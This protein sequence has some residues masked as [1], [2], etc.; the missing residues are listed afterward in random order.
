MV[1]RQQLTKLELS[2]HSSAGPGG[3]RM[4][5]LLPLIAYPR[6]KFKIYINFTFIKAPH[7]HI[8]KIKHY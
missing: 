8:L 1:R 4:P 3:L 5:W 2:P 6:E 7:V